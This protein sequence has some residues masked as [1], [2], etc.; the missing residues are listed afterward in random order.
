MVE[1]E[2]FQWIWAVLSSFPGI[3]PL[4]Q[5]LEYDPPLY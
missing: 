1:T 4:A 5:V 2:D 3:S